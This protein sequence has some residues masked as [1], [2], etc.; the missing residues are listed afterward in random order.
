MIKTKTSV[1]FSVFRREIYSLFPSIE[2]IFAVYSADAII[3]CGTEAHGKDDPHTHG[4]AIDL[5]SKHLS[6]EKKSAIVQAIKNACGPLY[7]VVLESAGEANEHIHI[8]IRKDLWRS[9]LKEQKVIEMTEEMIKRAALASQ[10]FKS[11]P[12]PGDDD[13]DPDYFNES[14]EEK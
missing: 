12:H 1:R 10:L 9:L 8:Q 7:Y 14:K 5:R 13:P 6:T 4:L 2:A 11:T 3:T